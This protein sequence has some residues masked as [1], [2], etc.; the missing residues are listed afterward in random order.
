MTDLLLID[1]NNIGYAAMYQPALSRLAHNG[2]PTGGILGLAQSVMRL[3]ALFPDAV[4]VVLWDGHA[5]WRRVLCPEYKANRKDTPE[6]IAVIE[7]WRQQEP[8]ARVLLLHLGVIQ[9]RAVD[10]EADDLVGHYC[11]A[12][13]CSEHI[14]RITMASNDRD[15]WQALSPRVDWFS[16]ITD[17]HMTI[18]DLVS[19]KAKD[20]PF[21][22]PA[23]YLLAKSIAGDDSD[24]IP[25]V[26]GVGLKTAVKL[27]Q[28]HGGLDGIAT[29]VHNGTAKDKKS[30]AIAEHHE[31]ILRNLRIMDWSQAPDL[32]AYQF[33]VLREAF[34]TDDAILWCDELGL[35]KLAER[36]NG[37][38]WTRLAGKWAVNAA[39]DFVS[40]P[41]DTL[42]PCYNRVNGLAAG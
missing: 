14:D 4:P 29:A 31:A 2:R 8:L 28:V 12:L 17:T 24:N 18:D 41:W 27:L 10:A 13:E 11:R 7:S 9:V 36:L 20:G 33:G 38:D 37:G 1:G 3:A 34:H 32:E 25:G 16:P 21:E 40:S 39:M 35:G 22:S 5:A 19:D 6:K 23:E 42:T 15:W 26:P 30:A